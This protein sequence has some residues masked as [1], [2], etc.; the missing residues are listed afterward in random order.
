MSGSRQRVAVVGGGVVGLSVAWRLARESLPVVIFETGQTGRGAGRVAAGMVAPISEYGFEDDV[1]LELGA[2]S[3]RLYPEYLSTLR[4]DSGTEV[5]I[6]GRGTLAVAVRRD[7]VEAMRRVYDFRARRGLPVEWLSGSAAR[8][9]EPLLSP[10]VTAGMWT[11]DDC[12]IDTHRLLDALVAACRTRGVEIRENEAVIGVATRHGRV[13]GVETANGVTEVDTVVVAAGCR[14]SD[15]AG[16]P[17]SATPPVRPV[18]GQIVVLRAAPECDVRHVI[19]APEAYIVPKSDGRLLVGATQEEMGFDETP[20]AGPVMRLIERAWEVVP[21]IYECAFESVEVGL[22]PGSRDH[23]PIIGPTEVDGLHFA[24]GH[25][26][27]GILL[28]PVTAEAIC[29]GVTKGS[30]PASVKAFFPERFSS[31]AMNHGS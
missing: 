22:R 26:R 12:H 15:I 25:F 27:H 2:E 24:T 29:E 13:V 6:D 4:E 16:I 5:D 9:F 23:L 19:R 10:R 28:S 18:K 30:Y 1:F 20:T 8:E 14:S 17:E 3:F 11:A 21:A 31:A 7:D